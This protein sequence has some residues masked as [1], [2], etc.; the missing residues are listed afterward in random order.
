MFAAGLD[1]MLLLCRWR[2][3]LN[4]WDLRA[5]GGQHLP[6]AWPGGTEAHLHKQRAEIDRVGVKTVFTF[7]VSPLKQHPS[8]MPQPSLVLALQRPND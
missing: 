5:A 4:L 7:L 6:Q 2:D 3:W 1:L 8:L